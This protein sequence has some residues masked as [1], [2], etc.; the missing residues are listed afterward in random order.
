MRSERAAAAARRRLYQVLGTIAAI[1]PSR[2]TP[3]TGP[4]TPAIAARYTDRNILVCTALGLARQCGL[5]AGIGYDPTHERPVVIYLE[6][7]T[8]QVSWHLPA[9]PIP[10]DGHSTEQKYHRIAAFQR[11]GYRGES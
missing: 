2:H 5:P 11:A 9:H 3:A 7:P 6:L 10:F 1:D 4:D 8:G